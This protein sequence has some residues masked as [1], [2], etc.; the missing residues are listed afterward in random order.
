MAKQ[1]YLAFVDTLLGAKNIVSG[2]SPVIILEGIKGG[3]QP[4]RE[5]ELRRKFKLSA[6]QFFRLDRLFDT[7]H[8]LTGYAIALCDTKAI[9]KCRVQPSDHQDFPGFVNCAE[10]LKKMEELRQCQL[11]KN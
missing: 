2:K 5:K 6:N 9:K 8:F 4:E 3:L 7:E 1:R 10:C 11:T